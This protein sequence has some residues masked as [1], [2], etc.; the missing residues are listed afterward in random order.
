[1]HKVK[2]VWEE[3]AGLRLREDSVSMSYCC[4]IDINTVHCAGILELWQVLGRFQSALRLQELPSLAELF[5]S[6]VATGETTGPSLS[7]DSLMVSILCRLM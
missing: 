2:C 3:F 1:M 5:Q 4:C 6:L 7:F